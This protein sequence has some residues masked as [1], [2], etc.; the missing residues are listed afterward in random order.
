MC[1]CAHHG[2]DPSFHSL[3]CAWLLPIAQSGAALG[4]MDEYHLE[5]AVAGARAVGDKTNKRTHT[6]TKRR[7]LVE[8]RQATKDLSRQALDR[9][10]NV[11]T[12]SFRTCVLFFV[13]APVRPLRL[14][15][16]HNRPCSKT[17]RSFFF[18]T[19]FP[20]DETQRFAKPGSGHNHL[21]SQARDSGMYKTGK[22]DF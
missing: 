11:G 7:L 10:Q 6:R 8:C 21:S 17:L 15:L 18:T 19:K 16:A 12:T 9:L 14:Q 2:R 4:V 3:D 5:T 20:H 1:V 22:L 13:C